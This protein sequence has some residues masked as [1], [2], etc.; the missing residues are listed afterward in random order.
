[1]VGPPMRTVFLSGLIGFRR[2]RL[3]ALAPIVCTLVHQMTGDFSMRAMIRVLTQR[4]IQ[5]ERAGVCACAYVCEWARKTSCCVIL[6][7]L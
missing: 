6:G 7:D 1:M 2:A 5:A 4:Q 3:S